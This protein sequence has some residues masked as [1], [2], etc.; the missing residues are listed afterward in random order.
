MTRRI[1]DPRV[2]ALVGLG[3]ALPFVVLNAIVVTRLEPVYSMI[4][5]VLLY[6]AVLLIK[7]LVRSSASWPVRIRPPG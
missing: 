7:A 3:L 5:A 6:T 2:A 1:T 4:P